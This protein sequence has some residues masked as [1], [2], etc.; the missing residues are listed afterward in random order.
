MS[1]RLKFA[2]DSRADLIEGINMVARAVSATMGAMGRN[3]VIERV[4][5]APHVT[6]DGFSVA[7]EIFSNNSE[8]NMGAQMIK[9]VSAKTVEDTGDGTT[10][11]TVLA[12]AMINEGIKHLDNGSNP[13]DLKRGIEKAVATVVE[14]LN[15]SA[16]P[17]ETEEQIRQVASISANNDDELGAIVANAIAKVSKEGTITVEESKTYDTYVDVVEGLKIHRGMLSA[18][19]ANNQE[20]GVAELEKPLIFITPNKIETVNDILPVLQVVPE[21]KALLVIGGEVS[22]EAIATLVIN[23]IRGGWKVA[24]IKAPFLGEKREYT[25]NDLATVTGGVCV[26]EAAG[27]TFDQFTFEMFGSCERVIIDKDSTVFIGGHGNK[28]DIEHLKDSLRS[29]AEAADSKYESDELKSRLALLSGGVAV[30]YVGANS[31]LEMKEKKDRIDDALGATRAAIEEGIVS[32]G[33]VAL[34]NCIRDLERLEFVK[35]SEDALVVNKDVLAG[36]DIVKK[37]LLRP[38]VTIVKNAGL[39]VDAVIKTIGHHTVGVGYDVKN[40]GYVDMIQAG[41]IDPK[42]VTRVA[43]ENA[44]SVAALVLMTECTIV[45]SDTDN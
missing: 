28:D 33:G 18:G 3:V 13:V 24:A 43:L 20:K 35:P 14:S 16:R 17:I 7:K 27:L 39:N 36:Y 32:G 23:K 5:R 30:L 26:S 15:K 8:I 6:K 45:N 42:K 11:A 40:G 25:L 44:A 4:G 9:G 22:G 31:E 29:Q 37:A 34:F 1:K 19:F 12:H 38:L 2:K 21:N 10:T 41:I